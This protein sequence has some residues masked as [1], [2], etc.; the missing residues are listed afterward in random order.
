M[1]TTV[2]SSNNNS[3]NLGNNKQQPSNKKSKLADIYQESASDSD[4][5]SPVLLHETTQIKSKDIH[6]IQR[7]AGDVRKGVHGGRTDV[8]DGDYSVDKILLCRKK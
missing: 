6:K 1:I 5:E 4:F 2:I 8:N 7:F 3:N